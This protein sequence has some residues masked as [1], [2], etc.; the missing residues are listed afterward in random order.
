MSVFIDRFLVQAAPDAVAAF[1]HDTRVL[2]RLTP[3]PVFVQIHYIE[4][5]GEGSRSEFTLWFGPLPLRWL[6]VH[7]GV[8]PASGFTDTQAR[9]PMK[10]WIH[11]HHWQTDGRGHTVMEDRVEYEHHAGARGLLTRLLFAP[12]LLW[13]MFRYRRFVIRRG[14]SRTL[15]RTLDRTH[16]L[17]Q[18]RQDRQ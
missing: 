4:P 18:K 12:P 15:K 6:A 5:L 16:N 8:D 13:F 9:G 11:R 3:P 1:H 10:R 2:K 14:V 7:T 17:P